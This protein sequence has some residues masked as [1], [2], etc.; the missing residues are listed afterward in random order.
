[1]L[2]YTAQSGGG[3]G[4]TCG[5][6]CLLCVCCVFLGSEER[7]FFFFFCSTVPHYT[8]RRDHP[9]PTHSFPCILQ[10]A[11]CRFFVV[12]PFFFLSFLFFFRLFHC[13]PLVQEQ[14][15]RRKAG[16][17]FF[18][19]FSSS[20]ER[21]GGG[22]YV[23]RQGIIRFSVCVCVWEGIDFLISFSLSVCACVRACRRVG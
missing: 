18:F 15:P 12:F 4:K 23:D 17:G 11:Q 2:V 22:F 8:K 3:E 20:L 19:F 16:L 9:P 7:G 6:P 14:S 21:L 5:V 10:S 1:M 13:S